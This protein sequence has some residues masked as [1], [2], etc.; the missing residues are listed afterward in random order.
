MKKKLLATAV[1]AA[2]TLTATGVSFAQ[3]EG[4]V[5]EEVV[6]TAQRREQSL[7]DV[8]IAVTAVNAEELRNYRVQTVVDI[9]QLTPNVDIKTTIAGS[10]PAITIRGVGLNDFNANNNPTVGVYVDEVFLTS[11]AM[12]TA[13]MYD[14]QRVE[15]LKG[16]QGTLY[17]R[18][19]NGGAI[20]LVTAKPTD[21]F[22]GRI[23]VGLGNYNQREIEGMVSGPLGDRWAGRVAVR[24][25]DT[26]GYSEKFDSNHTFGDLENRAGRAQ[27]AFKGDVFNMNAMVGYNQQEG[28]TVP[29]VGFGAQ[30]G[31][32]FAPNCEA[33]DIRNLNCVNFDG[34]NRGQFVDKDDPYKLVIDDL[35]TE[36]SKNLDNKNWLGNLNLSWELDSF[37]ITAVTGYVALDREWSEVGLE[38]DPTVQGYAF[39]DKDE[40][41]RQ[42]SQEIRLHGEN[43]LMSWLGG[44]FY[45]SDS[46]KTDNF[47]ELTN[48]APANL[49]LGGADLAWN[50]DQKTTS[51]AAFG[52]IE[53]NLGEMF[54][55]TTA[56]RYTR[57]KRDFEGGTVISDNGTTVAP[58]TFTDDSIS[59]G[60]W[61][62][63]LGLDIRPSDDWLVYLS[64]SNGFKS[65]GFTGDFTLNQA[66]LAPYDPETVMAYEA[67]FKSTLASSRVQLNGAIFHYKYDDLQG[68]IA[69]PS[70]AFPLT[71]AEKATVNGAELDLAWR[72]VQGLDLRGGIGTLS[73]KLDDD[74]LGDKLPNAPRLQANALIRYEFGL[75][76]SDLMMAVQTDAKYTSS[77]YR[78]LTNDEVLETDAYTLWNARLA[79]FNAGVD[80]EV[81]AWVK[82]INNA[83]Y[84]PWG[85]DATLLSGAYGRYVAPP[86]TYGV[87]FDY[88]F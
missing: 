40:E 62:G 11:T 54:T 18:N 64:A 30:T 12:L 81:A 85:F 75:G 2:T 3:E 67:G 35:N 87:S 14:M 55:L 53:W 76:G 7:Q 86:R 22:E 69:D 45:S 6:V 26:D 63:R 79:L 44:V 77:Q 59:E 4:W 51:A 42:I 23:H 13:M 41:I 57:E 66:E 25:D 43:E 5:I 48:V 36:K 60:R 71:N 56:A 33:S 9:A 58:F 32:G 31:A 27:L 34:F 16:P 10:N 17:G 46:V 78:E 39:I 20:N 74:R 28:T 1:A 37:T 84:Y 19:T 24:L 68:A 50:Y 88:N 73:T 52:H 61:T 65:G 70:G 38:H 21:E 80:W 29:A 8:G 83:E 47:F 49:L 15:V 82:N 72:P